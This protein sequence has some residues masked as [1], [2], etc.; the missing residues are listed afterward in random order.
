MEKAEA[1]FAVKEKKTADRAQATAEYVIADRLS[2]TE[3]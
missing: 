1:R 3:D 2:V